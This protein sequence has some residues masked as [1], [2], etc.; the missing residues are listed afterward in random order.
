MMMA[1][2]NSTII[3]AIKS[4]ILSSNL[5]MDKFDALI[6]GATLVDNEC[7]QLMAY[8]I[9]WYTNMRGIY[10]AKHLKGN[11]DNHMKK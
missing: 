6:A 8:V 9:D 7:Q 1:Y 11:S 5:A 3:S 2:N 10:F 4:R